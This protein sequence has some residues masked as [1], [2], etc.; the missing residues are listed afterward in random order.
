MDMRDLRP[1]MS[2][3]V[4]FCLGAFGR[5]EYVISSRSPDVFIRYFRPCDTHVYEHV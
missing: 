2:K 5:I 1:K 3:R 4:S